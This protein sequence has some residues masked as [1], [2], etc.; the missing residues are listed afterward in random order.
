MDHLMN[1]F[2]ID[3][4]Q[5]KFDKDIKRYE[6]KNPVRRNSSYDLEILRCR[7]TYDKLEENYVPD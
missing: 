3:V 5:V 7:E 4:F 6:N 2:D 1:I